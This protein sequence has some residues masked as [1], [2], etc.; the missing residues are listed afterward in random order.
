MLIDNS[1][2]NIDGWVKNG[3][4]GVVFDKNAEVDS[5]NRVKSLEFLL[6]R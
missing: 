5:K 4:I 1:N 2:K 6:R 3:G